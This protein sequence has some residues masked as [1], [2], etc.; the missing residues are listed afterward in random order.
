M[1]PRT[2][3][4][5]EFCLLCNKLKLLDACNLSYFMAIIVLE[6][7]VALASLRWHAKRARLQE[8]KR[9]DWLAHYWERFAE[10]LQK[11]AIKNSAK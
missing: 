8:S 3:K 6:T 7:R 10:D 11:T 1:T 9:S 4:R 5:A 2:Q